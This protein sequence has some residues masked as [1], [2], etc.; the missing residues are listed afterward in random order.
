MTDA[1]ID[2]YFSFRSP[3]SYLAVRQVKEIAAD[4]AVDVRVKVVRPLAVRVEGFFQQVNP[5]WPPYLMRDTCRIAE[6]LGTPYAW[7]R[8]DPI[9]QDRATLQVAAE[10]PY[11]HRLCRLGQLAAEQGRGLELIDTVSHLIWSGEA[12]PWTEGDRL[13]RAVE[14]AGLDLE[15]L[16]AQAQARESELDAAIAANEA[17][18]TAAGHWGVPLFVFDSEPFFGQD[19][20]V[21]L[22]WRLER[23]GTPR[24]AAVAA[25]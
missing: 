14:A 21:D 12:S 25:A 24:R 4:W 8:P 7:P 3:Y 22:V 5:L 19:R 13:A 18:Q 9:G 20:L 11:I 6:R 17:A 10:Q 1:P 15:A 2:F 23:A 16:D